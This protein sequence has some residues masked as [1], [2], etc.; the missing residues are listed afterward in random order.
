MTARAR[1]LALTEDAGGQAHPT[2]R[3]IL[4]EALKIVVEGV[5][6][7]PTRIKIDPLPENDRALYAMRANSW[8][9]DP[10]TSD[11]IRLLEAIAG[12]LAITNGFVVFHFDTDR[13]WSERDSSEHRQKFESLIRSKVRR[14]LEG[15]G[16]PSAAPRTRPTLTAEQ[17]KDAL[18]RL[19]ILTPCYSMES[20]LY[21]ATNELLAYCADEHNS[22]EHRRLI[23]KWAADRTLLDEFYRPKHEALPTCVGDRYNEALTKAFPAAEVWLAERSFYE[24]VERLRAC[25]AL[26]EALG[27]PAQTTSESE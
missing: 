6:L 21:Q 26:V 18:E 24:S 19:L 3:K 5:D 4:K 11:T 13:V 16:A 2:L 17:V 22:E 27:Y 12:Q 1:I 8:K 25:P 20:W 7:N 9:Q 10:P 14:I 23:A 15:E